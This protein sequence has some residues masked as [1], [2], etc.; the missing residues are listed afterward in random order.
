MPESQFGGENN[1][2]TF[3]VNDNEK[4]RTISQRDDVSSATDLNFRN[5]GNKDISHGGMKLQSL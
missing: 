1:N 3:E 4:F 5:G 2:N